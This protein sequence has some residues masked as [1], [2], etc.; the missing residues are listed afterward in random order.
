[1][2]TKVLNIS[3]LILM[4][5]G[6]DANL[7]CLLDDVS[8]QKNGYD[9]HF[10]R[11]R[12]LDYNICHLPKNQ[13]W[14]CPKKPTDSPG[15]ISFCESLLMQNL[16]WNYDE[17]SKEIEI[18]LLTSLF[19]SLTIFRRSLTKIPTIFLLS[20]VSHNLAALVSTSEHRTI[21]KMALKSCTNMLTND[22]LGNFKFR[23]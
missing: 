10:R 12:N 23:V 6:C 15:K 22:I 8:A 19:F 21:L 3:L 20:A 14:P 13:K 1:M 18:F 9:I 16:A 4:H 2:T 17:I 5:P 7:L 11:R